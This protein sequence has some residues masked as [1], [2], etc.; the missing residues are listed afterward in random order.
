MSQN[1]PS[2]YGV[3]RRNCY[4]TTGSLDAT[5]IAKLVKNADSLDEDP[6]SERSH[7]ICIHGLPARRS[8]PVA[9][10]QGPRGGLAFQAQK[11][12]SSTSIT[13]STRVTGMALF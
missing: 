13:C 10:G 1:L 7:V 8:Q 4:S 11:A 9:A 12:F 3:A 5:G 6:S 2:Y